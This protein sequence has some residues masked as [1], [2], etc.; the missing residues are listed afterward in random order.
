MN[1]P[2]AVRFDVPLALPALAAAVR[3][4][5][6]R[7]EALRTRLV[8]AAGEPRTVVQAVDAPGGLAL[9][10]VDL[11]RLPSALR[12][13]ELGRLALSQAL[14]PLDPARPMLRLLLVRLADA[15]H[16]LL[17]TLGHLVADGWSVEI[18]RGELAALYEA[19]AAGRPSPLPEPALQLA[20]FAAWQRRVAASA[21]GARQLAYWNGRLA[22]V[23]PPL[24]LPGD[25]PCKPRPGEGTV[26]SG[27]LFPP[28]ETARLRALAREEGATPAMALLAAFGMLLAAYTGET[29]LVVESSVLGRPPEL[30][31]TVGFFMGMLPHRLDLAGG[32]GLAAA[33]R[34]TR[35]GVA[36]DYLHQD[37]P[38]PR[39]LGELFPGRRYLSRLA[40]NHLHFA[41]PT[42]IE[43]WDR[44]HAVFSH[45]GRRPDQVAPKYDLV[46]LAHEDR[47]RLRLVL[48]GAAT[49]FHGE[50]VQEIAADLA[51]LVARALDDPEA[52][53]ARLLPAPH[54]RYARSGCNARPVAR[55]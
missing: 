51:A 53:A 41:R 20:D 52:P 14:S 12:E 22:G 11:S 18:L 19:F 17:V 5:T 23:P 43:A 4:L 21:A 6:R 34:R 25:W 15:D 26:Q 37:L 38:Y 16:A 28:E 31:A 45:Q 42:A 13:G 54:Y 36:E 35:D 39:L 40:F 30:A 1:L 8:A 29:D 27:C 49:R 48:L 46:L 33:M 3:E 50:T 10:L 55:A 47:E 7:H 44:E 9:P 24:Y 32:P 2:F